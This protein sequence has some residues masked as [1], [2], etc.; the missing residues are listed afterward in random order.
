MYGIDVTTVVIDAVQLDKAPH[1][2]G[3]EPDVAGGEHAVPTP[4]LRRGG[5]EVFVAGGCQSPGFAQIVLLAREAVEKGRGLHHL[6]AVVGKLGPA[7]GAVEA[8]VVEVEAVGGVLQVGAGPLIEAH[9][10]AQVAAVAGNEVELGGIDRARGIGTGVFPVLLLFAPVYAIAQLVV[11][12]ALDKSPHE[13]CLLQVSGVAREAI[14]VGKV[15]TY[16]DVVVVEAVGG[17]GRIQVRGVGGR[18]AHRVEIHFQTGTDLLLQHLPEA[19]V[20]AGIPN[21]CHGRET[22]REGPQVGEAFLLVGLLFVREVGHFQL[23]VKGVSLPKEGETFVAIAFHHGIE[24]GDGPI[25][26]VAPGLAHRRCETY[27]G[28]GQAASYHETCVLHTIYSLSA[29]FTPK[30]L[31]YSRCS[32]LKNKQKNTESGR[33]APRLGSK[34]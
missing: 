27:G 11:D 1:H 18:C 7:Y 16:P 26:V 30:G 17:G 8:L 4:G 22:A 21:G 28:K 10:G 29:G 33:S 31:G 23:V 14:E 24:R 5:K 19:G 20:E 9:G 34:S 2:D 3:R 32:A 25:V 12:A 13:F 6:P 15:E